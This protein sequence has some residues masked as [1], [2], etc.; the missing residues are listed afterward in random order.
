MQVE[1]KMTKTTDKRTLKTTIAASAIALIGA[2]GL[3]AA[4]QA[5][6]G[7]HRDGGNRA[8]GMG[9]FAQEMMQGLDQ[10]GN[11]T[12]TEAE[13]EAQLLKLFATVDADSSGGVTMEEVKAAY[14][15]RREARGGDDDDRDDYDGKRGERHGNWGERHDDRRGHGKG[16]MMEQ[17]AGMGMGMGRGMGMGMG[18]GGM[19]G[20]GVDHMFERADADNDG[21]VT[22]AEFRSA[23]SIFTDNI[24]ARA[25]SVL[26]RQADRFSE[27][28]S[29]NDGQISQEEFQA[30]QW[31]KQGGRR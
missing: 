7:S 27:L 1:L 11:G 23:I 24:A 25:N 18:M 15:A 30:G 8:G 22:E 28:D 20:Q 12:V 5:D 17:G 16:R 26:E 6:G 3:T 14:E 31:G 29:N 9:G 21:T 4:V 13:A 10:D 19:M 2:V